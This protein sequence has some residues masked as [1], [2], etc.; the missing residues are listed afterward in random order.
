MSEMSIRCGVENKTFPSI[1]L[2]SFAHLEP[3]QYFTHS[4]N[5]VRR[6]NPKFYVKLLTNQID[7]DQIP[8]ATALVTLI[9]K[10]KENCTEI[11]SFINFFSSSILCCALKLIT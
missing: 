8:Y 7:E 1:F 4:R 9:L 6:L 11:L 10:T 5:L 2:H 3:N